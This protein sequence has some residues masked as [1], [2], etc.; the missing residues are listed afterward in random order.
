MRAPPRACHNGRMDE[1]LQR[2]LQAL[3]NEYTLAAIYV[4][5]SR[6]EEVAARLAGGPASAA[7]PDSDVDV[8]VEPQRGHVLSAQDRVRIMQ[9]LEA[10]LLREQWHELIDGVL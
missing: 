8:G 3:A 5:G 7:Q 10:L 2:G 4:F 6:A 9:R 1:E